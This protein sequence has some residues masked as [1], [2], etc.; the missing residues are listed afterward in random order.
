MELSE[1]LRKKS[2]L[3]AS[4]GVFKKYWNRPEYNQFFQNKEI[5]NTA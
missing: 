2:M 1:N 3:A 5:K 4:M